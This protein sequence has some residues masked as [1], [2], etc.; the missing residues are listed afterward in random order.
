MGDNYD[1]LER[2][3]PVLRLPETNWR[4]STRILGEVFD[5]AAKA[6]QVITETD[7]M[8]AKAPRPTPV[9]AAVVSPYQQNGTVGF[10][11]LGA[12]LP[13]FLSELNIN[14]AP[15]PEQTEFQVRCF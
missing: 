9:K 7:A 10:Q 12:E 3:G 8:I 15:S 5:S 1:P 14:V 4:R 2:L 13:N 11:T 6:E